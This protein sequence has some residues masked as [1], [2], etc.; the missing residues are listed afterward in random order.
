[1]MVEVQEYPGRTLVHKGATYLYF[2]GTSYLGIQL[3]PEFIEIA[4]RYISKYGTNYGASRRSNIRLDIYERA[5]DYLSQWIG[6]EAS[7]TMSSGYL[8]GQLLAQHFK[9]SEHKLFYAPN[10]HSALYTSKAKPYTT[11]TTLNIALQEHLHNNKKEVPVIFIDS[12]DFSGCNYPHFDILR[13]LPLDSCILVVD[14]SHGIGVV[15]KN[16]AGVFRS[17]K[18]L[19]C[20]E[21]VLC[22][23][24]GKAV[25]IQAGVVTGNSSRINKLKA[26]DFFGGASPAAPFYLAQFMEAET[27][28]RQKRKELKQNISLFDNLT[29]GLKVL[30]GMPQYPVYGYSNQSMTDYLKDQRILVTDF[31]YPTEDSYAANRIV[32]TAAHNKEDINTLAT[33]LNTF[34]N[35]L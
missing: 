29:R 16:G 19:P 8:A 5:E 4:K 34:V 11:Y 32:L 26:S 15:G 12:I 28:Y 18:S 2:G 24:L 7:L 20:K 21:L 27:H 9:T 13:T 6:G 31:R 14:D 1:M 30:N 35:Q 22:A 17:L 33:A 10:S 3:E 25:G 23:S